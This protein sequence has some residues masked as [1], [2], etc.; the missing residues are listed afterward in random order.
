M[1]DHRI[2]GCPQLLQA[3]DI[4][5]TVVDRMR[6]KL[7]YALLWLP[8]TGHAGWLFGPGDRHEC[9]ADYA[10]TAEVGRLIPTITARCADAFDTQKAEFFRERMLCEA[11][12]LASAKHFELMR[13]VIDDCARQHPDP[14]CAA[15]KGLDPYRR[16]D[17][18]VEGE[19]LD[20]DPYW[21]INAKGTTWTGVGDDGFTPVKRRSEVSSPEVVQKL[22]SIVERMEKHPAVDQ[23]CELVRAG[24]AER[25]GSIPVEIAASGGL[26]DVVGCSLVYH[27]EMERGTQVVLTTKRM[28]TLYIYTV[29]E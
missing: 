18:C 5:P 12:G 20:V 22:H 26:R 7:V 8:V 27:L 2:V 28:G 1:N 4:D 15:G 23:A 11:S 19:Y 24:V 3:G 17:G 29:A 9:E 14:V 25:L 21:N 6:T 13:I 10:K 16:F